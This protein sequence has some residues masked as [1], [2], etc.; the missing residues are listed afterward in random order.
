MTIAARCSAEYWGAVF[1]K[2]R[3]EHC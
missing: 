2:H 3:R 1:R